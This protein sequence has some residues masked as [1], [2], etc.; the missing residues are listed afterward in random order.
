MG[1]LVCAVAFFAAGCHSNND[2][3]G[4]GIAWVTLTDNPADFSTYTVNVD[5]VT[6]TR[7]DGAVVTAL[8][9]P[10]TVDFTKLGNI[11]ELWGT[12]T[13]PIGTYTSASIILDYTTAVIAVIGPNGLPVQ[14]TVVD[15]VNF[16]DGAAV[17]TE[18]IT[19]NLDP[20]NY[21]TIV[22]SI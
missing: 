19:V 5:S 22:P 9:T 15:P 11:A 18:T 20:A 2:A 1:T 14:A 12:A 16:P 7:S 4:Y 10:E 17:T 3:S 21:L 13:I 8:A 6:L